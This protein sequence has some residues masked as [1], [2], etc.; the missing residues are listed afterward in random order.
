MKPMHVRHCSPGSHWDSRSL[1]PE[2]DES[3][4]GKGNHAGENVTSDLAVGP[5]PQRH[6]ADQIVVLGL[7]ESVFHHVA[8]KAGLDDLIGGPVGAVR[9]DDVFAKPLNVLSDAV[10]VFPKQQSPVLL[11][12]LD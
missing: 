5:V 8:V 6:D 10:V 11:V 12:F 1:E 7:P 9:D 3:K 2:F 4:V